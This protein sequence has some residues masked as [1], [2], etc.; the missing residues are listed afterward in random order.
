[1]RGG[2]LTMALPVATGAA[3]TLRKRLCEI[4]PLARL[5]EGELRA[6]RARE[7]EGLGI[8]AQHTPLE[9]MMDQC[10]QDGR[11]MK[12]TELDILMAYW[13]RAKAQ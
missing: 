4:P 13:K 11:D 10:Q 3:D 1:M 5:V 12:N 8:G 9:S 6:K 7:V 2:W